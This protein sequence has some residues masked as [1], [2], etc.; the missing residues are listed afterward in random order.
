[1][2]IRRTCCATSTRSG[3]TSSS[4]YSPSPTLGS[5]PEDHH[6]PGLPD[7]DRLGVP[8]HR[9]HARGRDRA[10]VSATPGRWFFGP[11]ALAFTLRGLRLPGKPPPGPQWPDGIYFAG[12]FAD[13][14]PRKRAESPCTN[15]L[16]GTTTSSSRTTPSPGSRLPADGRRLALLNAWSYPSFA[17]DCAFG[18]EELFGQR[19]ARR[20]ATISRTRP[21]PAE[22]DPRELLAGRRHR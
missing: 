15:A 4:P 13:S 2:P 3:S 7:V 17:L 14:G 12:G 22:A 6:S 8:G 10:L 1:V 11:R 19:L 18:R 5:V 20:R 16:N 21:A 9:R